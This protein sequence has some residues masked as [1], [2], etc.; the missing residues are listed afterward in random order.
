MVA[1]VYYQEKNLER[2]VKYCEKDVFATAQLFLKF[3]GEELIKE[4]N[5]I[6]V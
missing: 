5:F 3:K 4:E 1:Q 6:I 2:I